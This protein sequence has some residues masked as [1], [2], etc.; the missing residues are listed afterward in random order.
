MLQV[1]TVFKMGDFLSRAERAASSS[2]RVHLIAGST[3]VVQ[4]WL[5][6][7]FFSVFLHWLRTGPKNWAL[8]GSG[9]C[10]AYMWGGESVEKTA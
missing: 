10:T 6:V 3:R 5:G 4:I 8:Q 9:K 7:I 1:G 2:T